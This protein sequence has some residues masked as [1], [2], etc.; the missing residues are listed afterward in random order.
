MVALEYETDAFET[1][2]LLSRSDSAALRVVFKAAGFRSA[3]IS[4][5]NRRKPLSFRNSRR[6][7]VLSLPV[8]IRTLMKPE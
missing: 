3:G 5:Q 4:A 2:R 7:L 1:S 8:S 6:H